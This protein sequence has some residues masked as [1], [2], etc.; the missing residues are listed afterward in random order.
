[1]LLSVFHVGRLAHSKSRR[2][3]PSQ[4]FWPS[5]S[6]VPCALNGVHVLRVVE[7]LSVIYHEQVLVAQISDMCYPPN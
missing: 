5:L 4:V 1:M 3:S 6:I 2:W 7:F